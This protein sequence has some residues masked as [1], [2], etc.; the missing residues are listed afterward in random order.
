ML[1]WHKIGSYFIC[2]AVFSQSILVILEIFM[3][4]FLQMDE[5]LAQHYRVLLTVAPMGIALILGFFRKP[6]MFCISYIS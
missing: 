2:A 1:D 3:I 4:D 6:L 5:S